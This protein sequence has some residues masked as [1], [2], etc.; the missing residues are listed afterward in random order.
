MSTT[1]K[2]DQPPFGYFASSAAAGEPVAVCFREL[3]GPDDGTHLLRQ[4]ENLQTS[5]FD[6][7]PSFP[8]PSHVDH[9][10]VVIR[11][12]LTCT[13]YVNELKILMQVR[14]TGPVEAGVPAYVDEISDVMSVHIGVTIPANCGFVI[15]RSMGWR[16]SLF[17]DF[18]PL[19][20]KCGDRE[21]SIEQALA[22]QALLL[23]GLFPGTSDEQ[24]LTRL[25]QMEVGLAELEQL[26][27]TNCETEA[28]YQDLLHR[29]P[30]M[31]GGQYSEVLRHQPF[32]DANIPDFTGVRC[33]DKCHDIIE[34]KQP[35]LKLFKQDGGYS[36]AFND[37][38]NQS[39]RYL[40]LATE[41]RS[42]LL[43]E[44]QL[45]FENPRCL[46]LLGYGLSD[47]EMRQIRNK[48]KFGR[49][50]S[51]LTYDHLVRTATHIVELVKTAHERPVPFAD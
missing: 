30:W 27:S 46:L 12:D 48:E 8:L 5:L 34:L 13:A 3:I 9:L 32:D 35:F 51:V 11:P 28:S 40:S 43:D 6:K 37:A 21:Y 31:L 33:Y 14:T 19:N 39:E 10:L 16:R 38:W 41:Q 49:A 15:V 22:Q 29:H 36:A 50:I 7:I 45:R 42:Y 4:L 17:F 44:K 47:A 26:L 23:L 1:F 24:H 18:G 2:L 25:K 20:R